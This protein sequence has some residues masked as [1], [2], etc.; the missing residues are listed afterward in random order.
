ME[1]RPRNFCLD[2]I[3]I[4]SCIIIVVT[5]IFQHFGHPF[6]YF[7][8]IPNFYWVSIG[9]VAVSVYIIVSGYSL[10]MSYGSKLY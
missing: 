10:E 6:G 5:H 3:R 2:I 7:F 8:G 1:K 9:G 4:V